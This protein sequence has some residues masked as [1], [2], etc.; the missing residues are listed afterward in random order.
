M[1]H[2]VGNTGHL[3]AHAQNRTSSLKVTKRAANIAPH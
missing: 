1:I 3:E 2:E